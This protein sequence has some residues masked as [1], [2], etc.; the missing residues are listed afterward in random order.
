MS[1][2]F[3][4]SFKDALIT[5][6]NELTYIA[7]G[8]PF[9]SF[10]PYF[11]ALSKSWVFAW[12]VGGNII[13]SWSFV[14]WVITLSWI[15][16]QSIGLFFSLSTVFSGVFYSKVSMFFL[17]CFSKIHQYFSVIFKFDPFTGYWW[18]RNICT[19]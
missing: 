16:Q 8:C 15:V 5:N 18:F 4:Q 10:L 11:P 19:G 3:F 2:K 14:P 12:G 1:N 7:T 17:S 13:W 9:F 6:V